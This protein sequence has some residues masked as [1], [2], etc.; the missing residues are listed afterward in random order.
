MDETFPTGHAQIELQVCKRPTIYGGS[1]T[2]P[3][4]NKQVQGVL[5]SCM[6]EQVH[7]CSAYCEHVYMNTQTHVQ[8]VQPSDTECHIT[9]SRVYVSPPLVNR[10]FITAFRHDTTTSF[11]EVWFSTVPGAMHRCTS[12]SNGERGL[13]LCHPLL[14]RQTR[15][16]TDSELQRKFLVDLVF[17]NRAL[18]IA[19]KSAG[20][21]AQGAFAIT[22]RTWRFFQSWPSKDSHA[23]PEKD[24][25]IVCLIS[26]CCSGIPLRREPQCLSNFNWWAPSQELAGH[27]P[28]N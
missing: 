18:A 28:K 11:C 19:V 2:T 26:S 4:T 24:R 21:F 25:E 16:V 22:L 20:E 5:I 1:N 14:L 10:V 3:S 9:Q 17:K 27:P 23:W 8:V 15:W 7:S 6:C 12:R 13:Q